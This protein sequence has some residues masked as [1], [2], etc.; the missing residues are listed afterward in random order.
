VKTHSNRWDS[1]ARLFFNANVECVPAVHFQRLDGAASSRRSA[2]NSDALQAEVVAPLFTSRIEDR[3]VGCGLWI[4]NRLAV[5]FSQRARNTCERKILQGGSPPGRAWNNVIDVK[6]GLLCELRNAAVFATVSGAFDDG[7]AK[8]VRERDGL[9]HGSNVQNANEE[10]K[11]NRST[12][13]ALQLRGARLRSVFPRSPACPTIRGDDVRLR[14]ASA[15]ASIRRAL[16]IQLELFVTYAS[17][18]C[19][20]FNPKS[21]TS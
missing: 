15:A 3:S 18:P 6:R 2:D 12:R 1:S 9:T 7:P 10:G 11:A 13:Q 20:S 16:P 8:D 14:S 4:D 17:K 19:S 21:S 5:G